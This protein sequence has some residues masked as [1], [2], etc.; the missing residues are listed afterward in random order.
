M[1]CL[2][3]LYFFQGREEEEERASSSLWAWHIVVFHSKEAG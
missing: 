2:Q 1:T 3:I